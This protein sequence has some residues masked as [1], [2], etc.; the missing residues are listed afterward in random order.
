VHAHV[1]RRS[2]SEGSGARA[3]PRPAAGASRLLTLQRAGN[4]AMVRAIQDERHAHGPGCGHEH[5]AAD[6]AHVQL[7]TVHRA[8]QSP[9]HPLEPSLQ[10]EMEARYDGA[11]FS[12]VQVHDGSIARDAAAVIDAKAFA[13]GPH[14]VDGGSMSKTDWAHELAHTL[15]PKPARGTD[16]GA[17][18]AISDPRDPGE[19]FADTAAARAMSAP[20]PVQRVPTETHTVGKGHRRASAEWGG[21]MTAVA[22]RASLEGTAT[23]P[24][25]EQETGQS[26]RGEG[27]RLRDH[28][29]AELFSGDAD[30]LAA[31]VRHLA[32]TDRP[33]NFRLLLN[34]LRNRGLEPEADNVQQIWNMT[35][36]QQSARRIRVPRDLHFVWLGR[37]PGMGVLDNL[38]AWKENSEGSDWTLHL[39]TDQSRS[40]PEEL[41]KTFGNHLEIHANSDEW[42]E[43]N[44][45]ETYN[46]YL[47][48]KKQ[49]AYNV[50]SD[51]LR[52][53]VM[54]V[55]GGVYLD[56]D[57]APG[58]VQLTSAPDVLMHPEEAPL[59]APLLRDKQNV[60]DV[61]GHKGTDQEVAPADL[62]DAATIRYD[63]GILSNNFILTPPGSAFIN[64]LLDRL[65]K[66][67]DD[68]KTELRVFNDIEMDLVRLATKISGPE[69]VEKALR[70][71]TGKYNDIMMQEY[72]PALQIQSHPVI[73]RKEY[74]HLF[75]PEAL[76]FWKA[77]GWITPESENQLDGAPGPSMTSENQPD[78]DAGPG[79]GPG[80]SKKSKARAFARRLRGLIG[81]K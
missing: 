57:I 1:E 64:E 68:R 40:T 37:E 8:L 13:V 21:G 59:L 69:F 16:N 58:S 14:I 71:H 9:P 42:L 39:W 31:Y 65:A 24:P 60:H 19:R 27:L 77:L 47:K 76:E 12:A 6:H 66:D 48:A 79:P 49:E 18:L 46:N 72:P 52:Y 25:T 44:A 20:A 75:P 11:D 22:Q 23:E 62:I 10:R 56:V 30:R 4:A 32:A 43:K 81:K 70:N 54:K 7:A 3:A 33:D 29:G 51:I 53:T 26:T 38:N 80:P 61:L 63:E 78:A 34:R 15:D 55:H 74:Q 35:D 2:P 5:D 17:G 45:P 67:F 36:K 50:A 28:E 41:K 73:D